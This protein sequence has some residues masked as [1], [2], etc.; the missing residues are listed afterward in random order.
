[1]NHF[2]TQWFNWFGVSKKL[3]FTNH[4]SWFLKSSQSMSKMKVSFELVFA[5]ES[6]EFKVRSLSLNQ[7]EQF[8]HKW[9]T[10][11]NRFVCS[12]FHVFSHVYTTLSTL[13]KWN[14]NISIPKITSNTNLWTYSGEVTGL[15]LTSEHSINMMS[16]SSKYM[17]DGNIVHHDRVCSL[18]QSI[19][20]SLSCSS[21]SDSSIGNQFTRIWL[22]GK[23]HIS[24][25]FYFVDISAVDFVH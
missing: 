23:L 3:S 4:Y 18:I 7:S 25:L 24:V 2:A 22:T 11:L 1:M 15:L 21:V 17:L 10:Q 20:N 14:I 6:L 9:L 19:L 5:S 12:S 16:C 8:Q 13:Y